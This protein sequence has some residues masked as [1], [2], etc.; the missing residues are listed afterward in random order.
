MDEFNLANINKRLMTLENELLECEYR[1]YQYI[2]LIDEQHRDFCKILRGSSAEESLSELNK[3]R[4]NLVDKLQDRYL[5]S[6]RQI[7]HDIEKLEYLRKER[8]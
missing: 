1:Y 5:K 3:N 7:E 6:R 4:R 2:E 8:I